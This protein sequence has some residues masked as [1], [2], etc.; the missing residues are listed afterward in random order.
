MSAS[1]LK[2]ILDKHVKW[3]QSEKG[4]ERAY[5]CGAD[6][7]EANLR[8][9][10]LRGANLRGANLSEAN[11]RGAN[12]HEANLHEADLRG[13]DLRGA[14]LRGANLHGADLRGAD[15][16]EADLRGVDLRGVDLRG[17]DAIISF[18]PVGREKRIG[19]AWLDKDGKAIIKL[20]CHEGNL[21]ETVAAIR[22][23]YGAKSAYEGVVKACVKSLEEEK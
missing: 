4:G 12:L 14:D 16:H 17:A 22:A 13:A 10:D 20:G 1:E 9:A 19:Y 8:G 3:L 7:S 15:L 23:K 11:L 21:K 2:V 18:G 5:L 6:L